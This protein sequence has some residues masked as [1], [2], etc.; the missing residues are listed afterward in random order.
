MAQLDVSE[1]LLDPVFVDSLTLITRTA[2]VNTKGENIISESSVTT[3]GSV[4]PA[5][6]K[7][8]QRLPEALRVSDVRSFF[9]KAEIVTDGTGKYPAVISFG[10][11][12]FQVL[13]SAPWLNFG[14]GWNEGVCVAEPPS[15]GAT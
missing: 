13:T 1:L 3:V 9:I 5:S 10:G 11:K 8:I 7:Q 15:G 12:R 6:N 4:Q 14:A 2:T